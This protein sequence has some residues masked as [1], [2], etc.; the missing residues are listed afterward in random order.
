MNKI[1]EF[2]A[3]AGLAALKNPDKYIKLIKQIGL[4]CIDIMVND[5]SKPGPF[6]LYLSEDELINV[7]KKF[8]QSG[9]KV[10]ITTWAKP[11]KSWIDGMTQVGRIATLVGIEQ[12]TL[13]LEETWI[14][15]L[16][17]KSPIEI[18]TWSM[19]LI[20]TLRDSFKGVLA[21]APIVYCDKRVMNTILQLVDLIIPQCYSTLKNVPGAGHDGSL[22]K[23]TINIYKGYGAP[24][25]MGAA[26]WNLDGAYGKKPADAIRTSL[27][28]TL[29]LGI[30]EVRYW[31]AEFL[32]GEILKAIQ[33][34][35]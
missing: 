22:E 16:K 15:P 25:I 7:L 23:T 28:Q 31:R 18:F 21:V 3:W 19:S 5:G 2:G 14:T 24:I 34:F 6:H 29:A 35:I 13:D 26:A 4:N 17:T 32:N 1:T 33:E 11:E 30:T 8:K 27:K 9:I 10:S 12:L 20:Q